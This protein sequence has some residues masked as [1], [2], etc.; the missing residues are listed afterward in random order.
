MMPCF[1]NLDSIK[2]IF[3]R[4]SPAERSNLCYGMDVR[5]LK[6]KLGLIELIFRNQ[7]RSLEHFATSLIASV[8][9]LDD[10]HA[11]NQL[12]SLLIPLS[13][14]DHPVLTDEQMCGIIS[15]HPRVMDGTLEANKT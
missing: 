8:L 10:P 9:R 13:T 5:P 14:G 12:T 3:P 15:R 2:E 11:R 1:L 7:Q 6:T 4:L